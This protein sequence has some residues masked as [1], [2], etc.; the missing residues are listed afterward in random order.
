MR[1]AILA[2]IHGNLPA[3]EAALQHMVEH[4]PDAVI[5]AGDVVNG[6]PDSAECWQLAQSLGCPILRGNHERYTAHFGTSAAAPIW[7]TEQFAPLH[8]TVAQFTQAERQA[9]ANLPTCLRLPEAPDLLFVHASARDDHDSIAAYTPETD[10]YAM[11][12]GVPERWIIRG[13]NHVGQVR[14][15]ERGVLVTCG[16]VGLPLDGTPTAQYLLLDQG[17][18]G[19]HVQHQSVAYSLKAAIQRFEDS[20]YLKAAGP[21]GRLY[22]REIITG[23]H[24]IVPFLRLYGQW[25]QETSITLSQAVDRFLTA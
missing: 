20:G 9:M 12:A 18:Q 6:A 24:H 2:D 1:F 10:L 22:L 14:L 15:W 17:K 4:K 25:C 16:S 21:I 19:W 3:F 8:W 7:S 5:I 11:F 23:S 13:H